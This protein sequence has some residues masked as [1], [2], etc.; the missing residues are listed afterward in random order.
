MKKKKNRFIYY[1]GIYL[2]E[3]ERG[4]CQN[5]FM[6]QTYLQHSSLALQEKKWNSKMDILYLDDLHSLYEYFYQI[7]LQKN[8]DFALQSLE[9]STSQRLAR[10]TDKDG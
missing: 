5:E 4:I 7:I 6:I 8:D 9:F 2:G 3:N 10:K 1:F